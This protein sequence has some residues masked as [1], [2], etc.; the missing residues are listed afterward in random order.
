MCNGIRNGDGFQTGIGEHIAL[1][2]SHGRR[3]RDALEICTVREVAA[4]KFDQAFRQ[5]NI[6]DTGIS[7]CRIA[8]PTN[9]TR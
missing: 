5:R 4:C 8:N 1:N 9:G 3:Q 6:A 2:A 7:E